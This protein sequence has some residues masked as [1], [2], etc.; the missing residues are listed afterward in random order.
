[1][2]KKQPAFEESLA[3]LEAIISELE[4]GDLPLDKM[5]ER[6]EKGVRALELCRKVLDQAE[7]KIEILVKGEDGELRAQPFEPDASQ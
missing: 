6:Y 3:E 2:G 5:T 7:K 4:S 1:M